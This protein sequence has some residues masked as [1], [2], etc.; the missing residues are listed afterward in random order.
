MDAG[1]WAVE[2]GEAV[3]NGVFF[4]NIGLAVGAVVR[5]EM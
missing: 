1:E 5:A 2:E 3:L 4:Q